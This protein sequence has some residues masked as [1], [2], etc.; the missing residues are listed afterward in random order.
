MKDVNVIILASG[1]GE[2]YGKQKQFIKIN[3]EVLLYGVIKKW[4][5]FF[6]NSIIVV[7][8]PKKKVS[9]LQKKYYSYGNIRIIEGGATRFESTKKAVEYMYV[10]LIERNYTFIHDGARPLITKKL[11]VSLY[12][13]ITSKKYHGVIPYLP[14]SDSVIMYNES[15]DKNQYLNREKMASLQTPHVYSSV[16]LRSSL[17][18]SGVDNLENAE[19]V[20]NNKGRIKYILGIKENIK[21]T[22]PED[23]HIIKKLLKW[24]K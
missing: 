9:F 21:L 19:L 16:F 5:L 18:K 12:K 4:R 2:R 13:E 3:G 23:I 15:M 8:V 6:P 11:C 17:Q 1:K 10:N 24:K 20:Q 14:I 22:Y 7:T